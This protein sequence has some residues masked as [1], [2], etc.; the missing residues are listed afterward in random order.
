M[1]HN[2]IANPYGPTWVM[3]ADIKGF[4]DNISHE[5]ILRNIPMDQRILKEWLKAGAL[6]MKKGESLD[7]DSG[8]PQGGPIS[9]TIANMTLD[10]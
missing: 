4:F 9:P 3:D 5:W 10:G 6:D 7:T 2:V 8:V 1:I